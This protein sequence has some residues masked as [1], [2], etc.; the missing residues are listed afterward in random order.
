MQ[1]LQSRSSPF[2]G[3]RRAHLAAVS[4][5]AAPS[6]ARQQA[7][8]PQAL[9]GFGGG[10]KKTDAPATKNYICTACGW[11]YDGDFAKAPGSFKCPVCNVGKNKFKVYKGEVKGKPN[12]SPSAVK[13]RFQAK[14][15]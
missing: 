14:Q 2:L 7:A 10:A 15:W 6:R 13:Q 4:R 9:F 5:P 1:A 3:A 12:N 8:A 11:I